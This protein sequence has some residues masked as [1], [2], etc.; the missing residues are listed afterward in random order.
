MFYVFFVFFF[1]SFEIFITIEK[2][3]ISIKIQIG[4]DSMDLDKRVS[5]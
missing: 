5:R 3:S 4:A 1:V 2:I